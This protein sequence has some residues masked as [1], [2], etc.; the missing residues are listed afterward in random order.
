[1]QSVCCCGP[2]RQETSIDRCTVGTASSVTLS[3]DAEAEPART[4]VLPVLLLLMM[5][6]VAHLLIVGG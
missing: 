6:T 5:T 3:A 1:V 4:G 2:G